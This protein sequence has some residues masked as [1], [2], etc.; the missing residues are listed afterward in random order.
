M[1][2]LKYYQYQ[3]SCMGIKV[4]SAA[5]YTCADPKGFVRGGP[6]FFSD[7]DNVF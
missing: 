6:T 1:H 2:W 3:T 5:A 7:F 4:G